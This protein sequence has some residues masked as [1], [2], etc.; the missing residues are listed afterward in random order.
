MDWE[1]TFFTTRVF[2]IWISLFFVLKN[3]TSSFW[4]VLGIT[5]TF[6]LIKHLSRQK[7]F[8]VFCDPWK[9]S[10]AGKNAEASFALQLIPPEVADI[11]KSP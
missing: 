8:I 11:G 1:G 7:S 9:S 10:Q 6:F 3:P 2:N 4:L 5:F